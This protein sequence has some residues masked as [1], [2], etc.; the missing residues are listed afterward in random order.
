MCA[1]AKPNT[2][3]DR[4]L[5][6]ALPIPSMVNDVLY[7]DFT[8]MDEYAGHDYVMTIIDGLSRFAQCVPCRKKLDGE[9]ALHIIWQHW[10]QRY[11]KPREI[12][13]DND[14]HFSSR[15]GFWQSVLNILQ[16][17]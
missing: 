11:G 12:F 4:G 9:G 16:S 17:S 15:M 6:G 3:A 1:E 14:V 7:V 13:S 5:V 8:S 10:I 2:Q